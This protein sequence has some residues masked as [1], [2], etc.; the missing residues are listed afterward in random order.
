MS[1]SRVVAAPKEDAVETSTPSPLLNRFYVASL[2]F[3]RARQ[4][5]N[6]ARPRLEPNGHRHVRVALME[7]V[8]GLVSGES[9]SA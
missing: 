8:A 3:L 2:T 9:G 1:D 5:A 4:L 7:V 6:G